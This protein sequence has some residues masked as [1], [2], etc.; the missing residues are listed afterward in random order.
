M[1]SHTKTQPR[2]T[3]SLAA[4]VLLSTAFAGIAPPAALAAAPGAGPTCLSLH[5]RCLAYIQRKAKAA[6]SQGATQ[7]GITETECY[8]SYHKAQS[9]GVWPEHLPFNFAMS[10]TN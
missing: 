8:D 3:R 7:T 2:S 6:S 10:C 9:T 4:L 5:D 1:N